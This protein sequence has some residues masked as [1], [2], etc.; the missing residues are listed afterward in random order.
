MADYHMTKSERQ[1]GD[2]KE[3]RR[4]LKNGKYATIAMC[5]GN[6]PYVVTLSYGHDE[7]TGSLYFHSASKGLKIDFLR[8]NPRV[9]AT[10]IEDGGYVHGDCKHKYASLVIFGEMSVLEKTEDKKYALGVLLDHLEENPDLLKKRFIKNDAQYGSFAM[11][12]L[13]IESMTG[14]S[15]K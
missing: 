10:I 8:Q 3:I 4:L 1:I 13:K 2:E 7:A 5:R 6:E 9:C 14:K 11:L 15:G 12:K